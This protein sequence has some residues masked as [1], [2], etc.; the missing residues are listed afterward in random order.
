[1]DPGRGAHRAGTAAALPLFF[2]VGPKRAARRVGI[3]TEP[4][5][6]FAAGRQTLRAPF[7]RFGTRHLVGEHERQSEL[8]SCSGGS[9]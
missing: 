2:V 9:G 7:G 1:M 4:S 3:T 6:P 5:L 8:I